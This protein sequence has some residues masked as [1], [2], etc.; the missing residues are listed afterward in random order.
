MTS[1]NATELVP[2]SARAITAGERIW[3]GLEPTTVHRVLHTADDQVVIT[4]TNAWGHEISASYPAD[5]I[6]ILSGAE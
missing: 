1:T 6:Q 5:F 2:R 4:L 3:T